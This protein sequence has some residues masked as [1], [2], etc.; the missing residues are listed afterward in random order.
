MQKLDEFEYNLY[1]SICEEGRTHWYFC[2]KK[3]ESRL[4]FRYLLHS[5]GD[6]CICL[7]CCCCPLDPCLQDV[8]V[9]KCLE[10]A[11]EPVPLCT[12]ETAFNSDSFLVELPFVRSLKELQVQD[13]L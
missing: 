12:P 10:D 6:S 7:C 11:M 1:S 2:R 4:V 8:M 13:M 9:S 3:G 5:S